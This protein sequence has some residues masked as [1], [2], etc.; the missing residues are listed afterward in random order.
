MGSIAVKAAWIDVTGLPDG[1]G[2]SGFTRGTA[3]V[4]RATAAAAVRGPWSD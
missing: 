2:R 3:L 1:A 4:K